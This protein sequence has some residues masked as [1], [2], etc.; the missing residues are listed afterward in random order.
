MPQLLTY[1]LVG[2]AAFI[3]FAAKCDATAEASPNILVIMADDLGYGDLNCYGAK[4]VQTPNI[5]RLMAEGVRF[6]QFYANCCVCSPTRA[7]FLTGRYPD[8]VGVPGVI[9]TYDEEN[10]GHLSPSAVSLASSFQRSGYHTMLVGKWHLGLTPENHPTQRGFDKFRGFLG[11][12]MDDYWTHRRHGVNYMR[13][14]LRE[15]DPKGHATDLFTQWAIKL[16]EDD[17]EQSAPFFL[18]LSYNAP[19]APIQPPAKWLRRYTKREPAVPVKRARIGAFIEHLDDRVGRVL[20]TLD[21]LGLADSTVVVFTSDN[22]GSLR[23]GSSNGPL[24]GGKTQMYEGGLKVPTCI[25]WPGRLAPRE[26]EMRALTMDLL[27]T[28]A[29]LCGVPIDADIDGV[30]LKTELVEGGQKP[31]DRADIHTWLQDVLKQS[32]RVGRWK[33]VHERQ[34]ASYEL[35]NLAS[36]P[37]EES[38]LSKEQPKRVKQLRGLLQEHQ[39]RAKV[40]P[41][42]RPGQNSEEAR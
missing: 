16:L 7:A 4:H 35:Y 1:V 11:D 10:W 17:A 39:D 23:Y 26:S 37:Y 33:L 34:D 40:V 25:R 2:G 9:R 24:R 32:V 18:F 38:D 19:H 31:I 6:N 14:G 15:I 29:D 20:A 36:D 27:P 21:R 13:D 28:L 5:D 3:L 8:L 12:M 22:G 30:S 41:W 42:R